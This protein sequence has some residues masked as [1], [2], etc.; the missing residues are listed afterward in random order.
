[1]NFPTGRAEWEVE[2]PNDD[3]A[4]ALVYNNLLNDV[5]AVAVARL[6]VE[7]SRFVSGGVDRATFTSSMQ[8]VIDGLAAD[9]VV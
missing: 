2:L 1:M 6:G 9:S 7:Y 3:P 8:K 4:N 5:V